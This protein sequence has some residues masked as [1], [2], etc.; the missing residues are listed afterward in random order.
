M[1]PA[2]RMPLGAR[3]PIPR[4]SESATEDI[5]DELDEFLGA[6]HSA[7]ADILE[8]IDPAE[9]NAVIANLEDDELERILVDMGATEPSARTTRPQS[10]T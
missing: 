1:I 4:S 6:D 8:G 2:P 3:R 7:I 5:R 9:F 10:R